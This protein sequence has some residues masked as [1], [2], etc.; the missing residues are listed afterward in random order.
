MY[1]LAKMKNKTSDEMGSVAVKTLK[2]IGVKNMTYDN[3]KEN[4]KHAEINSTGL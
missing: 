3:G 4:V 2:N 1:F